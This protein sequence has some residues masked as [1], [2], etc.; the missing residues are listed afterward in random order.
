V[1]K[2]KNDGVH[3]E[4][5]MIVT[6]EMRERHRRKKTT[7]MLGEDLQSPSC[8]EIMLGD[9]DA[10]PS[11]EDFLCKILDAAIENRNADAI[12]QESVRALINDAH[13]Y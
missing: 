6:P 10:Q 4:N 2:L 12:A 1:D 5:A 7:R 8:G 3:E 11:L 13:K 9:I